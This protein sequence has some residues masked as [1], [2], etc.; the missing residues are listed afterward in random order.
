MTKN[1]EYGL[2]IM[3][4]VCAGAILVL[5]LQYFIKNYEVRSPIVFQN[6]VVKRILISPLPTGIQ[7][8]SPLPQ[9]EATKSGKLVT[10]TKKPIK[11]SFVPQVQAAETERVEILHSNIVDIIWLLE[12]TRGKATSGRHITCR[13]KGMWN[14]LG[15][16]VSV[17]HC[18][19]SKDEGFARVG[20]WIQEKYDKGYTTKEAMCM[21]NIGIK[22]EDCSYANT[23]VSML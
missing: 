7:V 22:T 23:L 6:P 1:K 15:F 10:P 2:T 12:T 14:E 11:R 17:A 9:K 18:F 4:G 19:T 16:A 8:I 20:S 5:S 13:N 3:I 21:Y